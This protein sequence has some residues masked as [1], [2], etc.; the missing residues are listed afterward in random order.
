MLMQAFEE[1]PD[2]KKND[3]RATRPPNVS[4]KSRR[5]RSN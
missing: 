5:R 2:L 1:S 3:S 4:I